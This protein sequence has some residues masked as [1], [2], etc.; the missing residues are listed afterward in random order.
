MLS[1][2]K[3][4]AISMITDAGLLVKASENLAPKLTWKLVEVAGFFAPL[5]MRT[6]RLNAKP[7][8]TV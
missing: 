5:R 7:G 3:H 4:P 6:L 1:E 2:A 8:V